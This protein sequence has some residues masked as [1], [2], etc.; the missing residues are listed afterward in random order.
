[1]GGRVEVSHLDLGGLGAERA[2]TH[3]QVCP[4]FGQFMEGSRDV[5]YVAAW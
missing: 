2:Q 5:R 1:M 4:M 3:T